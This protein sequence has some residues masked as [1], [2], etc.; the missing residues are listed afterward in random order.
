MVDRGGH[1]RHGTAPLRALLEER[2]ERPS[3]SRS[4]YERI[5]RRLIRIAQLPEPD[6]NVRLHGYIVDCVWHELRLV[7][8][9]DSYTYH[10][11]RAMFESD[12]RR[13]AVLGAAGWTVIR[14]TGR[15]LE[16]EP[17][18]VIATLAQA[19][20]LAQAARAA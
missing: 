9:V 4:R 2:L 3:T 20:S 7:V 14:V 19:L 5:L 18:A 12:R 13:D 10:G 15:Q 8:E 1:G 6:M 16:H 17:Y 11:S